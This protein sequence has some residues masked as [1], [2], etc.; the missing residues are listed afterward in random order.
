MKQEAFSKWGIAKGLGESWTLAHLD[1]VSYDHFLLDF[2][3]H[4]LLKTVK[5][6]NDFISIGGGAL[7]DDQSALYD[8]PYLKE[9]H[10]QLTSVAEKVLQ[11]ELTPTYSY[12]SMYSDNVASAPPHTGIS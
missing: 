6:L 10:Q 5:Q 8:P 7:R 9:L 2:L 12:L 4:I 3:P 11:R 1:A